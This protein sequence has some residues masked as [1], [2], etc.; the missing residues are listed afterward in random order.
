MRLL[1]SVRD[2]D[3]ALAAAAAGADFIDLKEPAGGALGALPPSRIAAVVRVLRERHAGVRISATTG[4]W[5]GV[6]RAATL[7]AVA[8]VAACGVDYVKVG[9]EPG[10]QERVEWLAHADA[11]VVPVLVADAGVDLPLVEQA[12]RHRAFPALMLDLAGKHGGSLFDV[13]PLRPLV[14]FTRTVQ[15]A[16]RWAG[17]AGALRLADVAALQALAPD[18]AGFRTALCL[19][20]RT[21]RLDGAKVRAL[22]QRLLERQ[23]VACPGGGG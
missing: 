10:A 4:E 15:R 17:V 11:T 16:G 6:G 18:F 8:A 1:A 13:V 20:D 14:D 9:V 3:E 23:A 2:V 19:G 12:L 22:R 21:G 5:R 7:D